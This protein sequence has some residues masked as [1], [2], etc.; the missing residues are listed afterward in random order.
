MSQRMGAYACTHIAGWFVD[1]FR[2]IFGYVIWPLGAEF[3]WEF[4][5]VFGH[6]FVVFFDLFWKHF[7]AC[8]VTCFVPSQ[9]LLRLPALV[10]RRGEHVSAMIEL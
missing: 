3:T 5:G 9:Q 10:L 7:V 6:C 2:G 4:W 8:F 1:V